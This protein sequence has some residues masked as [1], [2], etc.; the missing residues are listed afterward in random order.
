MAVTF[1]PAVSTND[2]TNN[3]ALTSG[4][5]TPAASD[6][7]LTVAV[8][9]GQ[10]AGGTFTDSQSLGWTQI[11]LALNNTSAD[12]LLL[13]V[14]NKTTQA[15]ST[16]VT[17]TPAGAPTS[18]GIAFS[19]LRLA[20]MLRVGGDAV[21]QVAFQ[22]NQAGGGTPAPVFPAVCMTGNPAFSTVVN[23]TVF[24]NVTVPSGWTAGDTPGFAI[25]FADLTEA[26]I[27]SGF[28]SATVTWG[29][30]SPDGFASVA[31][32]LDSTGIFFF[33]AV[34]EEPAIL[35]HRSD[36]RERLQVLPR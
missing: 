3:A 9:T 31:V 4:A 27:N 28:T 8:V 10:A 23:A 35:A 7:L 33:P 14:S 22:S 26:Y 20:G 19:V 17:F 15:I 6:L 13:A 25:P 5:F 1:T 11:V 30:T 2:T 34:G 24:P 36:I 29:S 21:R 16:T 18:T 32:E 12:A